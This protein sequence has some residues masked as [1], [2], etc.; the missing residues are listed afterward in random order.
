M[1]DKC[2]KREGF[3]Q[4]FNLDCIHLSMGWKRIDG[5]LTIV[6]NLLKNERQKKDK[7][8]INKVIKL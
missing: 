3:E 1:F 4:V 7:M 2:G 8:L 5:L 6:D